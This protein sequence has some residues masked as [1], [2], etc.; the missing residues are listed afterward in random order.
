MKKN[1]FKNGD[2]IYCKHN[3]YGTFSFLTKNMVYCNLFEVLINKNLGKRI[4]NRNNGGGGFIFDDNDFRL[5]TNKDI[6]KELSE[7][8]KYDLIEYYSETL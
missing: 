1:K 6:I 3:L 7:L 8:L 2:L 4:L 5:A